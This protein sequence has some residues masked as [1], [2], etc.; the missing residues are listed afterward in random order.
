MPLLCL[1]GSRSA[2]VRGGREHE[3]A[4]QQERNFIAVLVRLR[5]HRHTHAYTKIAKHR[6]A[7]EE[8]HQLFNGCAELVA[9]E[10]TGLV[11]V[12]GLE[13]EVQGG[14]RGCK[15]RDSC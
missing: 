8:T 1:T 5:A 2:E 3:V 15:G 4:A 12:K 7:C 11:R 10:S 13:R 9:V 14:R 6:N